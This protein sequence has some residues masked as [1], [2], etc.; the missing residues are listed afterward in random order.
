VISDHG[1]ISGPVDDERGHAENCPRLAATIAAWDAEWD[2][3][4]ADWEAGQ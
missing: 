1:L 4:E 3:V 2:A